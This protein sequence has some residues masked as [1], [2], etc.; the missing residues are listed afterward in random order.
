MGKTYKSNLPEFI[1]ASDIASLT[2][3][4]G[5]KVGALDFGED[6]CYSAYIVDD[7]AVNIPAY[8]TCVFSACSE[9][10]KIYDDNMLSFSK[11]FDEMKN[12]K[13]YRAGDFGC[14][15]QILDL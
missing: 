11:S 15:I 8:Y 13:I 6:G 10:L 12:I 3:R 2:V 9:W 7:I 14:I 4:A 1:G 5:G